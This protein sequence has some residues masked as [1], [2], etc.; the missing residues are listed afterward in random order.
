MSIRLLL[1][2]ILGPTFYTRD[3]SGVVT[4]LLVLGDGPTV[5]CFH[6]FFFSFR[7]TISL[8]QYPDLTKAVTYDERTKKKRDEQLKSLSPVSSM[9]KFWVT[10]FWFL[11]NIKHHNHKTFM[12]QKVVIQNF[13]IELTG[14]KYFNSLHFVAYIVQYGFF[15][16]FWVT[17]INFQSPLFDA[18]GSVLF[19]IFVPLLTCDFH[20]CF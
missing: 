7:Q 17:S 6:E 9:I 4:C 13:I 12:N 5:W 14:D 11:W 16:C 1:S 18:C 19:Y 8:E 2:A 20:S 3:P 10:T 15:V